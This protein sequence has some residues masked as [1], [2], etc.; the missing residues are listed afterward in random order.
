MG[1]TVHAEWLASVPL[2]ATLR[3]EV[4]SLD[5]GKIDLRCPAPIGLKELGVAP[6]LGALGECASRGLVIAA[7][8]PPAG[9]AVLNL[10]IDI[11]R[12]I[13]ALGELRVDAQILRQ[14]K[15][16]A[17]CDATA[18]VA[19]VRSFQPKEPAR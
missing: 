18:I 10:A 19:P 7:G 2:A 5:A 1:E 14:G 16:L 4:A 9:A 11:V 6:I 3:V 12:E 17:V 8:W 13:G 15:R